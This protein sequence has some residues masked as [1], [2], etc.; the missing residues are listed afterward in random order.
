MKT[1]IAPAF[2]LCNWPAT[3]RILPG[4]AIQIASADSPLT[5]IPI[6]NAKV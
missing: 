4:D 1:Q 5:P 3:A 2:T 6:A